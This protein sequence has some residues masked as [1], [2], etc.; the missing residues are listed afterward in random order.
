MTDVRDRYVLSDEVIAERVR[1][2]DVALFEILMRR[3]DQRLYRAARAIVRDN[4]DAKDIVQ[5][6]FAR[7]Y[8]RLGE[9]AG[10]TMFS[11]WLTRIAVHEALARARRAGHLVEI[12]ETIP[13]L[14][15]PVHGPQQEVSNREL[16]EALEV[17]IDALPD[18]Y[19]SVFML[20]DVE[21]L[22]TAETAACLETTEQT[23]KTRLHRARALLR[24]RLFAAARAAVPGTFR[25]AG[26]RC[27][28]LVAAVSARISAGRVTVQRK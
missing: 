3:Y 7:A 15:F 18:V 22:S 9:F 19:R 20:R 28:A 26:A 27:D 13:M 24:S 21:G 8:Q 14:S 5:D 6:A 10:R 25:F 4:D 17:A 2:G 16:A 11:T 1:G 12:E 23:T